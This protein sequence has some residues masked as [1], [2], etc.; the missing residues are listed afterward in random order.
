MF[1]F[2]KMFISKK[3]QEALWIF[4]LIAGVTCLTGVFL[5][6]QAQAQALAQRVTLSGIT[7]VAPAKDGEGIR[8]VFVNSAC[9]TVTLE[10][11]ARL[12]ESDPELVAAM[13]ER[14]V[15]SVVKPGEPVI[16]PSR[17]W[18]DHIVRPGDTLW[19]L[20]KTYGISVNEIVTENELG[21]STLLVPNQ[22][23]TIPLSGASVVMAAN[24]SPSTPAPTPA[25]KQ[26]TKEISTPASANYNS[27]TVEAE[28]DTRL[29]GL[30]REELASLSWPLRGYISSRFGPRAERIHEGLDIAAPGG[31]YI[32][33]ALPGVVVF[34]GVRGTYGN[35]VIL[36][37]TSGVRTLYAHASQL[38]VN[39]GQIV[40]PGQ[41]IALVGS[42]G[43][44]TGP[45]LH[46]EVLFKGLPLNPL[47]FL[48]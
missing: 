4:L 9:G 26:P 30:A 32:R 29:A 8:Q 48:H 36:K 17:G 18:V 14:A 31:D 3:L 7:V 22:K 25:K 1:M 11:V 38:L 43:H 15:D 45:H 41:A 5:P 24:D 20:A 39:Q 6:G 47:E 40:Q 28:D 46:F 21:L 12:M 44:S 13:N 35:A 27:P 19:G 16:M 23:L 34:A 42:T 33:A 37:H 2:K 10:D